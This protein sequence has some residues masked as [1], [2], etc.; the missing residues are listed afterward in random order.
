M[1]SLNQ[2]Y[3][4][5][6]P[7]LL[8]H[9]RKQFARLGFTFQAPAFRGALFVNPA[10]CLALL[11]DYQICDSRHPFPYT[12]YTKEQNA[13]MH[14]YQGLFRFMADTPDDIT[15]ACLTLERL[16]NR[17]FAE[18][19][20]QTKGRHRQ[21]HDIDPTMPEAL[22]EQAF[23]DCYGRR[24]LDR[25]I[26][27]FP[28]I[29]MNGHTRWVDY[30]IRTRNGDLAIEKNGET[31]HHPVI[32]GKERYARQLIKQNSLAAYGIKVFRW[33]IQGM[34]STD[35]FLDEM[36]LFFGDPSDF[37]LG[38]KISVSRGFSLFEHQ[39]NILDNIQEE[40][41]AGK[42]SFLVVLP[43]GTGKTEVLIADYAREHKA[44]RA[45]RA[46]VM[47]PTRQLRNDHA[48]KFRKRLPDHGLPAALQE[49]V[50]IQTYAWM[51]RNY[52]RFNS[53]AFD[54]IAVDEAHHSVAPTVQKVIQ[55]FTPSTLIGFT[56]TDHRLDARRLETVF[57][58]YDTDLGLLDAIRQGLLAPI[59]AF[60]IKSNIDL[61]EVRFNGRDYMTSDLQRR[62][63]VPSRDQLIVDT[64]IKYFTGDNLPFKQGLVFCV[65][66]Q[67]ARRMAALLKT[68]GISAEAVSG[69]D[70]RSEKHIQTYQ[71]GNIQ[72]LATCSLLNEGW[73]SPR[74]SVIVMARPTM[75]KVLY[76]QQLGRGTRTWP[77]KESLYVIDVVDNYGA[78]GGF[79]NQ[80][81]SIHALLGIQA[82]KPWADIL[83]PKDSTPSPEEIILAGLYEQERAIETINIFTFEN[84]YP[85]HLDDEQLARELFVSTG[86]VKAW[87]K[88]KKI[89]PAVTVPLGRRKINYFAPDQVNQIRQDLGLKRHNETTQYDD[90]FEFLETGDFTMS[91]KMVML[92]TLLKIADNSGECDLDL[93]VDDYTAFYRTRLDSGWQVDKPKC[94][95]QYPEKLDDKAFMK[96]SLLQNPFEKFE[97][98]R[99]LYHCKDLKRIAFANTLWQKIN[100]TR[101]LDR[102]KTLYFNSL[103]KYYQDLG[104]L[105]DEA[106]LQDSW[107]IHPDTPAAPP[108]T[109]PAETVN[110]IAF[111][112]IPGV[113]FRTALPLVGKIAAG[114]PFHGFDVHDL[115]VLGDHIDWVEVPE[116]L[117]SEKRY[118]VQVAGDSMD[119]TIRKGDYIVCE[120]HRHRQPVKDIVIMGDFS[121]LSDGEV[122]VKR[123]RE[124]EHAWIF[125][126]DNPDYEDIIVEKTED[127]QYPILGTVLYNLTRKK[128]I[129]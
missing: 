15:Q 88:N 30:F 84:E 119:P 10:T 16:L 9:A 115:T 79:K 21:W 76:T 22:F 96:T 81:W 50:T 117:C 14:K 91:Y 66:V 64:L 18:D 67:H 57:G 2:T 116:R 127:E 28:V 85:E 123:I 38:Q 78:M 104:G 6:D 40:R 101:D 13:L 25:V 126:S 49:T 125:K 80:A 99:F 102:I 120:Y 59:R 54:Y 70:S 63:V 37:L 108:E 100:T 103:K 51:C 122:A 86:T 61:S 60:R 7:G 113:R 4:G 55:S 106:A 62:V 8:R 109:E 90:F 53:S 36:K 33:S 19:S 45:A 47:V 68:H 65:S 87:V 56:A 39:E 23:I 107:Q 43:T 97:R 48:E 118:V 44:G 110:I 128:R 75:S 93:L 20:I 129:R 82:Y 52:T 3:H 5:I 73:D 83:E 35:N 89:S 94:P 46:L 12:L 17:E 34:T 112:D 92:L 72:F 74:T 29:D 1:T 98:K 31:F 58:S 111:E 77:G 121:T 41:T 11:L 24:A 27:E 124:S 71:A 26:R 42:S 69:Q 114:E 95:Y 105:P 32:I